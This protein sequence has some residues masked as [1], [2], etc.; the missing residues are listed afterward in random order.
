MKSTFS[1]QVN[2]RWI[3]A[4]VGVLGVRGDSAVAKLGD[5]DDFGNPVG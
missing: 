1:P 3:R 4:P 5:T 2:A